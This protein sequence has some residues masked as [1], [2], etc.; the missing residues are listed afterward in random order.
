[1]ID[2]RIDPAATKRPIIYFCAS[3]FPMAESQ[4]DTTNTIKVLADM[5]RKDRSSD[6]AVAVFEA[7]LILIQRMINE[8]SFG[9]N[10]RLHNN[11]FDCV[12]DV[13]ASK[14]NCQAGVNFYD[15][16]PLVKA[17][18]YVFIALGEAIDQTAFAVHFNDF[19]SRLSKRLISSNESNPEFHYHIYRIIL[20]EEA[21]RLL[22]NYPGGYV[23][24]VLPIFLSGTANGY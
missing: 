15:K 5:M 13:M 10:M 7:Y 23:D 14:T 4:C 17:A 19:S 24:S 12:Y 3:N 20:E 11:I 2:V 18:G 6:V 9:S 21:I 8:T 22:K 16:L 1:M